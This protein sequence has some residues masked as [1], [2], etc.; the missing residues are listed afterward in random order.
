MRVTS[1]TGSLA[2]APGIVAGTGPDDR[3]SGGRLDGRNRVRAIVAAVAIALFT[4]TGVIPASAHGIGGRTD[5]PV[6]L[7]YFLTGGAV[8][9]ILSFGALAALWPDPRLQAEPDLRP[10]TIPGFRVLTNIVGAVGVVGLAI[11]IASGIVGT[12]NSAR[13]P[14]SVLV[15]VG[16]WLVVPFA[17]VLFGNLYR[18]LNP[19]RRVSEWLG[20]GSHDPVSPDLG[21]WIAGGLFFAF[22]WFELVFPDSGEPR[23]VAALAIGYTLIMF[24]S[25]DRMGRSRALETVDAFTVYNGLFSAI[26]PFTTTPDGKPAVRGWLRGLPTYPERPGLAAFLVLMIGT[27][28]FD[29]MSGTPWYQDTFGAFGRSIVGGTLIMVAVVLLVGLGYGWASRVAANIAGSGWTASQVAS[30]FAHTLVPIAFAYAFAHYFTLVLFE[31]QLVISTMSDPLGTGLD[32]FGT[33][34]RRIDYTL[35]SPTGVWYVQVAAIVLGHVA[36]VVLAHD[37]ALADFPARVAVKTQYAML[38]LMVGLT[39]VGLT[40]LA[41]G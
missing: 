41:A 5:L 23:T 19:W 14:A 17:S 16:F 29:G 36:A 8:V 39:G 11:V 6:P 18:F 30:R 32:L 37:R 28:T 27:V 1:S 4:L 15:W 13:N 10:V 2:P 21:V 40:V 35:M 24:F 12:N 7:T 34:D 38:V 31:G 9:L 33:A 26:S 20:V 25:I 22:T 3:S